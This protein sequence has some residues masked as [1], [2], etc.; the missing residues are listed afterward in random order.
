MLVLLGGWAA[1][2]LTS[3]EALVGDWFLP[4]WNSAQYLEY[5]NKEITIDLVIP[6]VTLV[7]WTDKGEVSQVQHLSGSLHC[8]FVPKGRNC[9]HLWLQAS[10]CSDI[11]VHIPR[12]DS[13][14]GLLHLCE[15]KYF[16]CFSQELIAQDKVTDCYM[17]WSWRT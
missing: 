12:G 2:G 1:L 7:L 5:L 11:I 10:P 8:L 14:K 3:H 15:R 16:N 13:L 17:S 6:C 9:Q 4:S